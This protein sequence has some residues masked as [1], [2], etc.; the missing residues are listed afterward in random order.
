M[1]QKLDDLVLNRELLS[2]Q[3]RNHPGIRHRAAFLISK[4]R[5]QFR[6]LLFQG[7]DMVCH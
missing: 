7:L 3:I 1:R 5:L 2:F 4:F 6:M